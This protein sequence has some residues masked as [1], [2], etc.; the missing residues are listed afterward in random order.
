MSGL[1]A[2]TCE[3]CRVGAPTV[4]E[5][6]MKTLGKEVP[7]WSVVERDGIKQ[8]ERVFRFD[9][10]VDALAF[11]NRVGDLAE[12]YGHH[13][14]LL[15]EWGKVTVTWWSHKIRGLHRNDYVMAAKTDALP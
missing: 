1:S 12:E 6:E 2:E 13:P 7:E 5:E 9:N 14:A 10:F 3:A 11:T 15:T 4:T 8:L